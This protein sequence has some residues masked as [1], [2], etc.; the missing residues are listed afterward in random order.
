MYFSIRW[1]LLAQTQPDNTFW[2][3]RTIR[4]ALCDSIT[5]EISFKNTWIYS[6]KVTWGP[7]TADGE[8]NFY[9]VSNDGNVFHW[10]LGSSKLQLTKVVSL[11]IDNQPVAG[12]DG[13]IFSI[14]GTLARFETP[15]KNKNCP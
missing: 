7:D 5:S 3:D 10:I 9:T 15:Q 12:P 6:V 11:I 14:K 13:T 2:T 8:Y 4:V 1:S